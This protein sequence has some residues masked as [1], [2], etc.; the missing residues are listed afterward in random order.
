MSTNKSILWS[1]S[2]LKIPP[3]PKKM[4]EKK[5]VRLVPV[6]LSE[7]GN[8][9]WPTWW[10]SS[11]CV[12]MWTQDSLGGERPRPSFLPR[13]AFLHRSVAVSLHC[14][15]HTATVVVFA[16]FSPAAAAAT[17]G[18]SFI[19]SRVSFKHSKNCLECPSTPPSPE[20]NDRQ[21]EN[22]K[23]AV[24]LR[25]CLCY[26]PPRFEWITLKGAACQW[27]T[28]WNAISELW[29]G[30]SIVAEK[31]PVAARSRKHRSA[32]AGSIVA[33]VV[34]LACKLIY[35]VKI[36]MILLLSSLLLFLTLWG[37]TTR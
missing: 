22:T 11:W 28:D 19:L 30:S 37:H 24:T 27:A 26:T 13:A 21:E 12:L 32:A 10:S 14:F 7:A 8:A 25:C 23:L 5:T 15:T 9:A 33:A 16:F 36:K 2:E 35:S 1:H 31:E 20:P 29:P 6:T 18:F 4:R 3:P 34:Y 17:N